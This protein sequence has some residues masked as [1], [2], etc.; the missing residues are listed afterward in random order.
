MTKLPDSELH[1]V[2]NGSQ[3]KH[4]R[5][6]GHQLAAEGWA[7]RLAAFVVALL[8]IQAATGLWIY[9]TTFSLLG[10]LQ[11]ILHVAVGVVLLVPYVIYQVR[12]FLVWY[13]QK[14]T[15]EMMVGYLLTLMVVSCMVSGIVVTWNAWFGPKLSYLWDMVHVISGIA[16]AILILAHIGMALIRRR[17]AARKMPEF[18]LAV[19]RFGYR[20]AA[21]VGSSAVLVGFGVWLL[22]SPPV[23]FDIPENYSLSSYVD[24]FDEYKGNPFA[25]TYAQT[26]S[27]KLV[28]PSV[29]GNSASCG[30]SGCHQEIYEEWLPSAHR[31]SAMNPPFQQVQRNFAN[32]R[33]PAETRY[34][35]GCHDPISLFAGAKD[36]HMMDTEAPGMQEGCSCVACHSISKVDQRGNADYVLTPPEKYLW[37][38]TEGWRK[39]V[40]DFMIR[41]YPRQHLADYDRTVLRTPEFCGACHKQF[42]PEAL[43]RTGLSAGQNQYDEWRQSHWHTEDPQSDLTCIDCHMRLVRNSTDPGRGESGAS[44]RSADDK[45]HRHH[46]TIAT[47]TFMPMVMK[48]KNWEKHCRMTEE[49][50]RGE[51]VIEE[52]AHLWPSGPIASVYLIGPKK[53]VPGEPV[54]IQAVVTNRK[55]GHNFTT[56]PLDFTRSWIHLTVLDETGKTLAEWGAID[57]QSRAITDTAGIP[58]KIA[59]SRK[60]G[61]LVLEAEPLDQDG[62]AILR[63]ELWNKAGGRGNRV[64]FPGY[65]DKQTYE[66][67]IP[68]AA[69]G[70]LTIKAELNFRRYRQEFLDLVVPKMEKESGVYQPTVTQ[71][72]DSLEISITEIQ[73]SKADTKQAIEQ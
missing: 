7:S 72:T 60:E 32:D 51:T 50:M 58:H 8:V 15:V 3:V 65:S 71:S 20:S 44:R 26:S 12:H 64:I 47:N 39:K 55:A 36:I 28:S 14:W 57:P 63:H 38:D 10:E 70:K 24:Q 40:S 22:V 29:L 62:N 34:C 73:S 35:A 21:I 49:W 1:N 4:E 13:R 46:G 67:N 61:T 56:G 11:L 23:E 18:A 25:P 17:V 43:N 59:N 54:T 37:E 45:A 66:F 30:T 27:G 33:E 16:T 52:I 31:F 41:A 53:V 68:E 9:L 48:L 19:R 6:A 42:I 2:G 5:K 69:R